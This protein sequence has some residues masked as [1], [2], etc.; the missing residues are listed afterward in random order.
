[1]L[2]RLKQNIK[3]RTK[4]KIRTFGKM[5]KIINKIVDDTLKEPC[6]KWSRKNLTMFVSLNVAI[7]VSFITVFKYEANA[8]AVLY[9]WL[10]MAT[11]QSV[12]MLKDKMNQRGH[13]KQNPN[14]PLDEVD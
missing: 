11:G 2:N 4:Q 3:K 1:M 8:T 13:D 6:G 10:A 14:T 9:A 5:K 7:V 12:L